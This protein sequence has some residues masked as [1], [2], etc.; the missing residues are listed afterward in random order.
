[1]TSR[2]SVIIEEDILA[3]VYRRKHSKSTLYKQ[4]VYLMTDN[5]FSFGCRGEVDCFRGY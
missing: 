4:F 1:M 5:S 3:W 2:N